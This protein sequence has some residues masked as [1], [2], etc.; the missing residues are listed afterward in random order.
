MAEAA[1]PLVAGADR[2]SA[3]AASALRRADLLHLPLRT[4]RARPRGGALAQRAGLD[5]ARR[6]GDST[7]DFQGGL[8]QARGAVLPHRQRAA[9]RPSAVRRTAAARGR[10]RCRRRP[11]AVAAVPADADGGR[12][13]PGDGHRRRRPTAG[14]AGRRG[15]GARISVAPAVAR[16]GVPAT[17]PALRTDPAVRGPHRSRQG[18]R[19]ADSSTSANTRK[20]AATPRSH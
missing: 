17:T 5:G 7:R 2:A 13:R 11:A 10:D 4:D 1:G 9:V 15:T 18:L 12:R 16:R 6:A 3:A 14:A 20:R 19:R 8:Q